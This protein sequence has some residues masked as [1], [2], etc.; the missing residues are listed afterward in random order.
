MAAC[1]DC[2]QE[3]STAAS[4]TLDTL[5]IRNQ[6]VERERMGKPLGPNGRCGDCGIQRGGY[7]HLGC[8]MEPCPR[9]RRQ[10]LSCGCL[11]AG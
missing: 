6:R 11:S 8:D 9:C 2:G 1:E 4:C 3:M 10:L 5:V 7:H